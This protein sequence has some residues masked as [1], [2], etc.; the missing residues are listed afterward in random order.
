MIKM[1]D[2]WEST[3]HFAHIILPRKS[4]ANN[5]LVYFRTHNFPE[6]VIWA[7]NDTVIA[8]TAEKYYVRYE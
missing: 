8:I 1:L 7:G 3:S 6:V 2:P 5:E 4:Y